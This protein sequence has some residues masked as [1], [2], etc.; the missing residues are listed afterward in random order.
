MT[1]NYRIVRKR[2]ENI[3]KDKINVSYEYFIAEAYYDQ[4]GKVGMIS[5]EGSAL[6]GDTVGQL[7]NSFLKMK[8]AF[9]KP[10]LDYHNIPEP[11]Y[12]ETPESMSAAMKNGKLMEKVEENESSSY[13]SDEEIDREIENERIE[14][15]KLFNHL[16]REFIYDEPKGA[17]KLEDFYK[18]D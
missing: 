10:I 16:I 11:G 9:Y 8:K 13:P 14:Q 17:I 18:K 6:Y 3:Y 5:T 2:M 4:N 1:W 12:K 7:A 15:D